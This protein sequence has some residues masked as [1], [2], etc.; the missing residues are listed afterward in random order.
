MSSGGPQDKDWSINLIVQIRS[1]FR[2]AELD[3]MATQENNQCNVF[4]SKLVRHTTTGGENV[5]VQIMASDVTLCF[6]SDST[7]SITF[8]GPQGDESSV[9][10]QPNPA[11]TPENIMSY[12]RSRAI[13]LE[14]FSLPPHN[15]EEE[16]H[17]HLLGPVCALAC[18]VKCTATLHKSEWLFIL[19][20][21][22]SQGQLFVSL[23]AKIFLQPIRRLVFP[24]LIDS[25]LILPEGFQ[26][27]WR[28][29]VVCLYRTFDPQLPGHHR[30]L[31]SIFTCMMSL[32]WL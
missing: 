26:P 24:L 15:S 17:S 2:K 28:Y 30:I 12:F 3:L 18:Y 13:M 31:S 22:Q 9:V 10:L 14:G 7:N 27:P 4:L 20:R 1:Q 11:F 23:T 16:A 29:T 8:G 32:L 5:C 6:S 19:F 21:N 25:G